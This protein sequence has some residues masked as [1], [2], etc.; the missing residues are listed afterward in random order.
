MNTHN[1]RGF[2]FV[3]LMLSLAMSGIIVAAVY[4]ALSLQQKNSIAQE[5]V[6]EMQ[7]NI[8]VA[9][10][11]L[12]KELRMAGY[13]IDP[14]DTQISS[15]TRSQLVFLTDEDKDGNVTSISYGF[16]PADDV[17]GDGVV[18][19]GGTASFR[20]KVGAGG[21]QPVADHIEAIEFFYSGESVNTTSPAAADLPKIRSVTVSILS[22][23]DNFD[24]N[25]INDGKIY[26]S[27]S[28]TTWDL[29]G[30]ATDTGQPTTDHFRRRLLIT[31]VDLRNMGIESEH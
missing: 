9:L 29:N 15:A 23:A 12:S 22:K 31:S 30:N 19:G 1:N 21:W 16:S 3:E 27:F 25:Y 4:S 20:R 6:L 10:L 14:T 11:T 7:Q 28:G 17:D 5:Q 2:T 13:G 8:R 24:K 18:D 26:T